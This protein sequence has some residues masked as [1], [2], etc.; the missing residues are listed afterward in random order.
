LQNILFSLI[1]SFQMA[2]SRE[3]FGELVIIHGDH[4]FSRHTFYR[5]L[6]LV[7]AFICSFFNQMASQITI[8]ESLLMV[9]WAVWFIFTSVDRRGFWT[10]RVLALSSLLCLAPV[11]DG[12]DGNWRVC[13][14]FQ[15]GLVAV[16]IWSNVW[17]SGMM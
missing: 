8:S 13:L 9:F 7:A 16:E 3:M 1:I 15:I 5:S 2:R 6:S 11:T 17:A 12:A 4:S 14:A 10:W